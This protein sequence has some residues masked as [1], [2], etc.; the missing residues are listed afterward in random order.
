MAHAEIA[1]QQREDD[2]RPGHKGGLNKNGH[3]TSGRE[4][5]RHLTRAGWIRSIKQRKGQGKEQG[6][7]EEGMHGMGL[8][9]LI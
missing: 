5:C 7:A 3:G 8:A 2:G 4:A 9:G 1:D 6:A